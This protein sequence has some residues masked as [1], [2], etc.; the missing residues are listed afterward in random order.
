MS[1]TDRLNADLDVYARTQ[2]EKAWSLVTGIIAALYAVGI[3]AIVWKFVFQSLGLES[4]VAL[5]WAGG[6]ICGAVSLLMFGVLSN[7]T[8]KHSRL[9]RVGLW[10]GNITVSSTIVVFPIVFPL[11]FLPVIGGFVIQRRF[12]T[13]GAVAYLLLPIIALGGLAVNWSLSTP[14]N[15][16]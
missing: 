8:E 5:L 1:F 7:P 11:S 2:R 12:G 15:A 10:I 3:I 16:T 6:A 14:I 13:P 4:V 9:G